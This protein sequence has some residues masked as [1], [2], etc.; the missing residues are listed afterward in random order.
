MYLKIKVMPAVKNALSFALDAKRALIMFFVTGLTGLAIL[1]SLALFFQVFSSTAAISNIVTSSILLLIVV[2]L[3]A[4]LSLL[5]KGIF[6]HNYTIRNVEDNISKSIDALGGRMLS[7]LF[8]AVIVGFISIALGLIPFLGDIANIAFALA[9]FFGNQEIMLGK[10][11]AIDSITGAYNIFK[12][13]WKDV[14]ASF[15]VMLISAIIIFIAFSMPLVLTLVLH[16]AASLATSASGDVSVFVLFSGII[17]VAG[18]ALIGL[19]ITGFTTEIYL[20][21]KG[22]KVQ[23]AAAK[24]AGIKTKRKPVKR[25]RGKK[26]R[27]L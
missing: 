14:L 5:V 1:F 11:G 18:L 24:K 6:I 19:F 23:K 2:M 22:R 16:T 9:V 17:F 26:P 8:F 10:K 21:L 7:I 12:D 13:N 25:R 3:S 20:Q 4:V 15:I 27:I